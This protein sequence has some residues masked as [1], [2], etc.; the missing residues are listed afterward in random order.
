MATTLLE[1][2]WAEIQ[3]VRVEALV[4]PIKE[5]GGKK[6]IGPLPVQLRVHWWIKEKIWAR[7]QQAQRRLQVRRLC[8]QPL[9]GEEPLEDAEQRFKIDCNV[10]G[11]VESTLRQ[12]IGNVYPGCIG[13]DFELFED[14]QLVAVPRRIVLVVKTKS[15]QLAVASGRGDFPR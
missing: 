1:A 12:E 4:P 3:S 13:M 15:P 10:Y 5:L 8:D 11:F 6:P 7:I 2:L 14:W 9:C